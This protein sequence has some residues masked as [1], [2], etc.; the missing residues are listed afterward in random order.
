MNEERRAVEAIVK[1][2]EKDEVLGKRMAEL[3]CSAPYM[4]MNIMAGRLD[5]VVEKLEE[6]GK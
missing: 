2:I 5:R 6:A 3:G 1:L 4:I